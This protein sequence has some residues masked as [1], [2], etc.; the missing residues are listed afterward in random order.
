MKKQR[1]LYLLTGFFIG[2]LV[3]SIAGELFFPYFA[4]RNLVLE[5]SRIDVVSEDEFSTTSTQIVGI[6]D[7]LT[8]FRQEVTPLIEGNTN[9]LEKALLIKEWVM[10]QVGQYGSISAATPYGILTQMREGKTT[11]CANMALV[12]L[13]ALTSVGFKARSVQLLRSYYDDFDTH[14][15]VEV[16]IENQWMV[17]D[18]TFNCY[19]KID[20]K[21]ASATDLHNLLL[22]NEN[23]KNL[24]VIYGNEVAY[25]AEFREYY[26]DPLLLYNEVL[27]KNKEIYNASLIQMLPGFAYST[28]PSYTILET[29]GNIINE[30]I[31]MHRNLVFTYHFILPALGIISFLLSLVFILWARK[32]KN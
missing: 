4:N 21:R 1:W 20:S 13:S 26:V 19:F 24:E 6:D 32:V 22:T 18:P 2:L 23:P 5:L 12:Y 15:T 9:E 27:L 29:K 7:E 30:E 17:I 28:L 31:V 3:F 10:N 11:S 14:V 8:K 16:L 25:P